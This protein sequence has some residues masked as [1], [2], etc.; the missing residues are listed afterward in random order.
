MLQIVVVLLKC[1]PR[2]IWRV[3]KDTS[4]VSSPG[5]NDP[6]GSLVSNLPAASSPRRKLCVG[7]ARGSGGTRNSSKDTFHPARIKWQQSHQR[8]QVVALDQHVASDPVTGGQVRH[9]LQQAIGH[10]LRGAARMSSSRVNQFRIGIRH[11]YAFHALSSRMKPPVARYGGLIF[12]T[13]ASPRRQAPATASR[14]HSW[15]SGLQVS[16][17]PNGSPAS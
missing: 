10:A 7:F 15:T 5:V 12:I 6:I 16:A 9:L 1:R 4:G 13:A 8:I 11:P 3:N 2:V 17:A 14:N